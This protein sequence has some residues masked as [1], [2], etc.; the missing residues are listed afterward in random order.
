MFTGK[1]THK[2][3][4]EN[5][6]DKSGKDYTKQYFIVEDD[7][8]YSNAIKV[9]AYNKEIKA[10]LN[11]NVTVEVTSRVNDWLGK[12]YSSMG[13]WSLKVNSQS[14]ITNESQF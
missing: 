5:G 3:E 8:Q 6:V 10:N 2:S 4:I 14:I 12:H 9:E 11:D 7:E 1:I 13:L